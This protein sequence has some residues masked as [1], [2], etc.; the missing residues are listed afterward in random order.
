MFDLY[1]IFLIL[2]VWY[3]YSFITWLIRTISPLPDL[4]KKYGPNSWALITGATD[5]IGKGFAQVLA[6]QGFNIILS[7]RNES[8]LQTV[9]KE[10]E[11]I[12]PK[13]KIMILKADYTNSIEADFFDKLHDKI[14][15]LDIS[16]LVNNVGL[17]L[18]EDY[19]KCDEKYMRDMLTVNMFP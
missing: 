3:A 10:L 18:I 17:A 16:I 2:A 11:E 7:A 1:T 4:T 15:N 8:K 6:K 19:D 13:I 14:K 12:N 9:Q 5:G